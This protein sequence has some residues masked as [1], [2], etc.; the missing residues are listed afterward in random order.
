VAYALSDEMKII[1]LGWSWRSVATI[2]V[3]YLSHS[4]AS[5]SYVVKYSV[6]VKCLSLIPAVLE[7]FLHSLAFV[8]DN[9]S[10]AW[11]DWNKC[12]SCCYVVTRN[13]QPEIIFMVCTFC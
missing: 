10:V 11:W 2:M 4:W 1:D 12:W 3:G 9:S 5:C 8:C 7:L 6:F 13:E